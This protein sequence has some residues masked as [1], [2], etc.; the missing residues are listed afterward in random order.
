MAA[1]QD[2]LDLLSGLL[3]GS[4]VIGGLAVDTDL[5]WQ[6]VHRLVSRGVA[7]QDAIDAEHDRTGP[8]RATGTR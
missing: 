1:S 6:L 5:R 7:G 3:D 2:D 8:M 4:A